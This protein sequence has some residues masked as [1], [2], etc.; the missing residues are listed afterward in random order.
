MFTR[1]PDGGR[2]RERTLQR[3]R[4]GGKSLSCILQEGNRPLPSTIDMLTT[5]QSLEHRSGAGRQAFYVGAD[6]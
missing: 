2:Q 6:P 5:I 1:A 3:R 4:G